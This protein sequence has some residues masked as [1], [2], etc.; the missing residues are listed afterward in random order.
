MQYPEMEGSVVME[1]R[2]YRSAKEL[3]F[4][5]ILVV[6]TSL[7]ALRADL[8]SH[9]EMLCEVA[10]LDDRMRAMVLPRGK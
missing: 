9:L 5:C 10:E 7:P 3:A 2:G 4:D 6:Q 8:E 1:D